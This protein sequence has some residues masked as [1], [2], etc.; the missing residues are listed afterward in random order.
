MTF[1]TSNP[2]TAG[3]S[4]GLGT[5]TGW[6]A[7]CSP[8]STAEKP[9]IQGPKIALT[10]AGH[11]VEASDPVC[12]FDPAKVKEQAKSEEVPLNTK[13]EGP[14]DT[15]DNPFG[16]D[17]SEAEQPD[18]EPDPQLKKEGRREAKPLPAAAMA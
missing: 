9:E 1:K 13:Q 11:V 3:G 7:D 14:F 12:D 16:Y 18:A 2:T 17:E 10:E 5:A 8:R 15:E 4:V 6:L